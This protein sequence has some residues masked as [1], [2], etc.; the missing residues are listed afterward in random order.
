M[1]VRVFGYPILL[2]KL[3]TMYEFR[4]SDW[5]ICTTRHWVVTNNLLDVIIVV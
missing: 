4:F 1:F 3:H 2:F 5:L